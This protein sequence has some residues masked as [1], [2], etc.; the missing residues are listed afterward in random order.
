MR[1]VWVNVGRP[2]TVTWRG[3]SVTTGIFKD[4]VLGRV[5]VRQ[6]NLVSPATID[7]ACRRQPMR[8]LVRSD[9]PAPELYPTNVR[10]QDCDDGARDGDAMIQVRSAGARGRTDRGSLDRRRPFSLGK[11]HDPHARAIPDHLAGDRAP[12]GPLPADDAA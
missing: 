2:R 6:L 10:A 12:P 7:T 9:A 3:R 5:P 8:L 4:P 1:I 11:Y